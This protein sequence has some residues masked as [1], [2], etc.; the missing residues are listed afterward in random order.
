MILRKWFILPAMA[1]VFIL[2]APVNAGWVM[3]ELDGNLTMISNGRLKGMSGEASWIFYGPKNEMIFIKDSQKTYYRGTVDDYCAS[4][5]AIYEK[6]LEDMPEEQRKKIAK[7]NEPA[8][9]KVAVV[10][11]DDGATIAGFK[12][13]KYRVLLDGKLFEEV[14]LTGDSG[15][16]NDYKPLIP[17]LQKFN[18]CMSSMR[19]GFR[20][21]K[22]PDYQK[23]LETG[24][25][26]KSVKYGVGIPKP[27][28]E[29]AKLEKT[30]LPDKQFE[31][32]SDY[33]KH[34]IAQMMQSQMDQQ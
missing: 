30:D 14:W 21:D 24:F 10:K 8:A 34:S 22:S 31:M 17:M 23:L 2:V 15:L 25:Q 12:T 33:R 26:L 1:A 32:P 16:M 5:T 6:M 11:T 13:V 28:T 20:P 9:H 19:I 7:E 18:F 29:V 4:T 27:V 3:L